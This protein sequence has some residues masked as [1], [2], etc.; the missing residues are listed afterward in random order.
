RNRPPRTLRLGNPRRRLRVILLA[1]AFVLSLFAGRLLQLQGVDAAAYAQMAERQRSQT[2]ILHATRGSIFDRDGATLATSVSAVDVSADPFVIEQPAKTAAALAPLL[3]ASRGELEAMLSESGSRWEMLEREVDP[4]VWR[5]IEEL[6]LIGIYGEPASKRVYPAD[7]VAAN[8]TGFVG[9]GGVPLAGL[10]LSLNDVLEGR[11]GKI[12]FEQAS[13]RHI[14]TAGVEEREPVPGRDLRLTIDRDIQWVAQRA[15]AK[16]VRSAG[17]DRGTVVV[18][19]AGTGEVLALA[20]APTF[21][22]NH[23]G[24]APAG[25]RGNGALTEIYEPGSTAKPLTMAAAIEEGAV[26]PTTHVTVPGALRRGG[27]VFHDY[28]EHDTLRLT[29]TGVLAESS[30]LG[31]MLIAER[32]GWRDLR[33]YLGRFGI[34]EPTGLEVPGESAGILAPLDEWEQVRGYTVSFGQGFAVN[35]VQMTSAVAAIANQGVRVAPS[36]V[37]GQTGTD[38]EFHAAARPDRTRVVSAATAGQVARMMEMV[39]A[40]G[41]TASGV[42]IPGYRVAGKTGTAERFDPGCG[43]YRGYTP[44]FIGFAPADEPGLVVSVTI[45]NPRYGHSGSE[46]AAPVFEKVMS[47]ALQTMT[48]PPTGTDAPELR[49]RW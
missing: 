39:T 49:L 15:I 41:G 42:D 46:L 3:S 10:E 43:C 8:V 30:N 33:R 24:D 17:A 21:D 35:A 7:R 5:Q 40:D 34:G 37:A 47:F 2:K 27:A 31:T 45:H 9:R 26:A 38:G 44:S 28:Y 4:L 14:T 19:N 13:G 6:D 22:A 20:V 25:V 48:T 32:L 12:S 18:M 1:V 36:L 29:A 16:Q 23:P 11:D